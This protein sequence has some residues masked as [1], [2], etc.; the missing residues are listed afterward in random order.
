M[1][2]KNYLQSMGFVELEVADRR[3]AGAMAMDAVVGKLI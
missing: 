1:I 3:G 2:R